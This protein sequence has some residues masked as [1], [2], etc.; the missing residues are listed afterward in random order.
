MPCSIADAA[1]ASLITR[2][3]P[4]I[5]SPVP[6]RKTRGRKGR[7]GHEP[8]PIGGAMGSWGCQGGAVVTKQAWACKWV[9]MAPSEHAASPWHLQERHYIPRGLF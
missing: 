4:R 7:R 3:G 2:N 1:I 9:E 5:L 6:S 8:A